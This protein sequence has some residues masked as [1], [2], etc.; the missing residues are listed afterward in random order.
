MLKRLEVGT[1]QRFT[2]A[3]VGQD[4][5]GNTAQVGPRFFKHHGFRGQDAREGI[6]HQVGR[7]DRIAQAPAQPGMQ[8]A[9]VAVV[10][11][12]YIAQVIIGAG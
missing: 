7:I 2:L 8:P 4:A 12:L 6:L 3:P 10:E 1:L 5:P 9:L 11:R